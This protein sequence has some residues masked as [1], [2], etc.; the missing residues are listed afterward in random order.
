MILEGFDFDDPNPKAGSDMS[1]KL[2][3]LF[4]AKRIIGMLGNRLELISPRV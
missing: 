1:V 3:K 2:R 4:W